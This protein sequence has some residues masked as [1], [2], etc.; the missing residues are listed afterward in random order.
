MVKKDMPTKMMINAGNQR[1]RGDSH[2][3]KPPPLQHTM[4]SALSRDREVPRVNVP[5]TPK[6]NRPDFRVRKVF[7]ELSHARPSDGQRM[8]AIA[9]LPL[10]LEALGGDLTTWEGRTALELANGW[11]KLGRDG[12]L[13]LFE[14]AQAARELE[15]TKPPPSGGSRPERAQTC[16]ASLPP[17]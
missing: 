8:L 10:A 7:D 14:F 4:G 5:V 6:P 1:H 13:D 9:S 15:V 11:A 2:H 16:V 12:T 3:E 17:I